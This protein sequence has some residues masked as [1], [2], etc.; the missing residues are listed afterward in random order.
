[1]VQ[2]K[3]DWDNNDYQIFVDGDC[4]FV[5]KN[6]AIMLALMEVFNNNLK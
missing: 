6:Y 5:T 4:L 2:L 1:M 3:Y